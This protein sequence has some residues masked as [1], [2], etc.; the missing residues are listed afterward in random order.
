MPGAGGIKVSGWP[1]SHRGFHNRLDFGEPQDQP[2]PPSPISMLDPDEPKPLLT[3]GFE[4]GA[5]SKTV[6][7]GRGIAGMSRQSCRGR[8]A[9]RAGSG[10]WEV[11]LRAQ[12][13]LSKWRGLPRWVRL[14]SRALLAPA[15]AVFQVSL[16]H[17]WTGQLRLARGDGCS[18]HAPPAL[19]RSSPPSSGGRLW[20]DLQR[21]VLTKQAPNLI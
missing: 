15:S 19:S 8:G 3:S 21:R 17:I 13:C 7:G 18:C 20:H 9:S 14:W 4:V 10:T 5:R 2:K 12:E 16:K 6:A 1:A 11:L